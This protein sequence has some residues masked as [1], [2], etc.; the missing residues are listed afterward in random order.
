MMRRR[1]MVVGE[2]NGE[3]GETIET[4][5][6]IT[7]TIASAGK[8]EME[9]RIDKE[10]GTTTTIATDE[11]T[12]GRTNIAKTITTVSAGKTNEG[13]AIETMTTTANVGGTSGETA[14]GEIAAAVPTTKGRSDVIVT[15]AIGVEVEILRSAESAGETGTMTTMRIERTGRG[16]TRMRSTTS[17]VYLTCAE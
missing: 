17:S 6:A 13:I 4:D 7:I 12:S 3:K 9:K 2:R 5:G 14:T 15:A 10:I 1:T 16:G 8:T 11:E